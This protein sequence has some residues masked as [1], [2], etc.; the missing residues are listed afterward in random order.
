[1]STGCDQ[2]DRQAAATIG[3]LPLLHD[4]NY[5]TTSC[6]SLDGPDTSQVPTLFSLMKLLGFL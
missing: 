1:M 2:E 5:T 4:L 3:L 6:E